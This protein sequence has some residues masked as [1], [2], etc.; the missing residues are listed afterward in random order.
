MK[1]S[2]ALRIL[3]LVVLPLAIIGCPDTS[4]NGQN[5]ST[6]NN[7]REVL[8]SLD[9]ENLKRPTTLEERFSYTYGYLL[10]ETSLRSV[11][12]IDIDFFIRGVSDAGLNL[13]PLLPTAERNSVLYEY[14]QN[15]MQEAAK[16]LETLAKSNLDDAES[17]LAVNGQREEIKTTHSGLQ[18][19]IIKESEGFRPLAY[20]TVKVN[21]KLTYLDGRE[22]DAS[23]RGIPSEFNLDSL[24]SGF[25]EGLMLMTEGSQ[26]RFFV[27][28]NLGYGE[29]GST[30]IEP[31][32]LL[33][34]DV[35]LVEVIPY[36]N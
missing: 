30:R 18:Y 19:E 22:G 25:R 2:L 32:T 10:M 3:A 13:I 6:T 33:I 29:A 27:H 1:Y 7:N 16:R 9:L 12:D 4:S 11:Q 17:F 34:F 24:I 14:Q 21:Y 5:S 20:D 26:F 8:D 36:S 31:N 28:P 15:L 35:E 23:I